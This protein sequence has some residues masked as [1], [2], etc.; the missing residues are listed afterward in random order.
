MI[1]SASLTPDGANRGRF[2]DT[3]VDALITAAEQVP[4][5]ADQIT[6]YHALQVR[7]LETLPLVPLWYEDQV[8]AA[9]ADI[10]GYR[11]A[12]DGNYDGLVDVK[13]NAK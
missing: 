13:R 4:S 9:R 11:L 2:R 1:H 7:L 5:Q 6:L 12:A 10:E 8:Y 3:T